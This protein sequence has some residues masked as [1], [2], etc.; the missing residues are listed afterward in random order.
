VARSSPGIDL[1]LD[2]LKSPGIVRGF[3][4]P[5]TFALRYTL[6]LRIFILRKAMVKKAKI[7]RK[8]KEG[9]AHRSS[10]LPAPSIHRDEERGNIP[11]LSRDEPE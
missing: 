7:A 5:V 2:P 11:I 6:L 4:V 3:F 9:R 1:S 8:P 10:D